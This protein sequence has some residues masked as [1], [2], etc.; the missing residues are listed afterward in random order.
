MVNLIKKHWTWIILIIVIPIVLNTLLPISILPSEYNIIGGDKSVEVW[1]NFFS[2]YIGAIVS[3]GVAFFVLYK[4]RKDNF[5]V[6]Q[7]QNEYS[8]LQ[9]RIKEYI[10]Y[11]DIYNFNN[12]KS[13]FNDWRLQKKESEELKKD[14]K[15]LMD[16]AF[17]AFETISLHYP[18]RY[19]NEIPFF[20]KQKEN[21]SSLISFLQDFQILIYFDSKHWNNIQLFKIFLYSKKDIYI[22]NISIG[23]L[24][25][26][27][28]HKTNE[29]P[30][31]QL[32]V[33]TYPCLDLIKIESQVR[34]YIET[35]FSKLELKYQNIIK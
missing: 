17:I 3:T 14:I 32:L 30:I 23:F 5:N 6:I 18:K 34:D 4:N 33:N 21:Y 35:E 31:F 13:I 10:H 11:I 22:D 19:F 2:S 12:I 9:N 29:L 26:I 27:N 7:Y 15:N 16:N 24:E 25:A 8:N 20:I 28:N 1:L